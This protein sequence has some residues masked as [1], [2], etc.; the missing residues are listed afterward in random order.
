MVGTK[1][2]RNEPPEMARSE[3][4]FQSQLPNSVA[5]GL[6]SRWL[7][8]IFVFIDNAI[9]VG[10]AVVELHGAKFEIFLLSNLA[11]AI[12]INAFEDHWVGEFGRG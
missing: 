12:L 8:L 5:R 10:V 9:R 1:I 4:R 6:Q 7:L 11:I 2:G 3:G